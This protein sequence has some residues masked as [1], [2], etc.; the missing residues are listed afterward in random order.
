MTGTSIDGM[1]LAL[2]RITGTGLEMRAGLVGFRSAE[3]GTL[4]PRLRA[5]AEGQP[6]TAAEFAA[7]ALEFGTLHARELRALL[8]ASAVDR[9]DLAAVHGQTV[10]HKPPVSWQLLN[11]HPIAEELRCDVVHDLRGTDLAS[12]GQGAPLTPLADWILYRAP[13]ARAVVNL[14]GFANVT[15]LPPDA[16][17]ADGLHPVHAIRGRDVCAC[18]Q[19]LDRAARRAID[20]AFDAEGATAAS[21]PPDPDAAADLRASLAPGDAGRSLGSGDEAFPW[22]DRH[23]HRLPAAVLLSTVAHAV[24]T[25]IGEALR[26]AGARDVVVAGG[27]ARHRPLVRAIAVAAGAP[28]LDS[29]D[30]GVPAAARE[31]AGWAVLGALAQDGV[32]VALPAITGAPAHADAACCPRRVHGSWIHASP[33]F[34]QTMNGA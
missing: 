13:H 9:V 25:V 21:A 18:N 29:G 22:I 23:A 20:R 10:F 32:P 30:L 34:P 26:A 33:T 4:G 11:A 16:P 27:G 8:V 5:A 3:L 15:L 1:D 17:P 12:G 24:G 31:A 19:L 7:L 2:V 14:G 6:A 28:V